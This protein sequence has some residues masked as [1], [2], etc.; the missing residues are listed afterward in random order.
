M[1]TLHLYP[2][3]N[4]PADE[5]GEWGEVARGIAHLLSSLGGV[6]E[7]RVAS[8]VET[9]LAI[10][11]QLNAELQIIAVAKERLQP[12]PQWTCGAPSKLL[13]RILNPA[14]GTMH[15]QRQFGLVQLRLREPVLL[16]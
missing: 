10:A 3:L 6:P 7:L 9:D 5:G 12:K 14:P 16:C 11:T 2:E 4:I 15:A 1:Y 8:G 13:K